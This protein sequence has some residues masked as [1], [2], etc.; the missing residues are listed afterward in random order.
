MKIVYATLY[1][2]RDIR[3]GSGTFYHLG[4]ALEQQGHRVHGLGPLDFHYPL[5]SRMLRTLTLRLGRRYVT[6]L[7]PLVGHNTGLQVTQKLAGLDYDVLLTNDFAVAAFTRTERPIVLYTDAM[8]TTDYS[9]KRLPHS[10]LAK[11][12]PIGLAMS[13]YTIRRGLRQSRLAVFPAAW[14]ADAATAY[15]KGQ[16]KIQ[17]LPFGAN[18]EDPGP[19]LAAQ[20]S[21][22]NIVAKGR[23]D[24]LFVG[25]DWA[26]KGGD[27]AV[28]TVVELNRRGITAHLHVVGSQP[29]QPVDQNLIHLYG[30]LDKSRPDELRQLENLYRISDLFILPSQSE[31]YVIVVLEA[32]AYGLPTLAYKALGVKDAV[33][34][35]GSGVLLPLG[36]PATSFADVIETWFADYQLY[37]RL[38]Q[39]ARRHYEQSASWEQC[40]EKLVEM[41]NPVLCF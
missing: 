11:L 33:V 12:T 7:D 19:A 17:I 10:R 23:L 25:K 34:D 3:R 28:E 15:S 18:L 16:T 27:I 39:G 41:I 35:G 2:A 6:F 37:E 22:A 13:R 29:P 14:S 4:R 8:I 40:A 31:G 5:I 9:E 32:A 1:D 20:R 38:V 24:L 26:R 21:F 30:V 36:Q